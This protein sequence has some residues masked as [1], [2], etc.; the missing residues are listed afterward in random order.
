[1][2]GVEVGK[3]D[4]RGGTLMVKPMA[5]VLMSPNCRF[6]ICAFSGLGARTSE[7]PAE[8]WLY[9]VHHPCCKV[10]G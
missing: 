9:P 8:P 3:D 7:E 6:E 5:A 2:G 1:M 4:G 10:C